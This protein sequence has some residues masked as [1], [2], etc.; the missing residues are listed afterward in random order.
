VFDIR[1]RQQRLELGGTTTVLGGNGV[2]RLLDGAE[3][4][5]L[6]S[7]MFEVQDRATI[8]DDCGGFPTVFTNTGT[9]IKSG[10]TGL[11]TFEIAFHNSGT[12]EVQSGTLS[13]TGGFVQTAGSLTLTGGNVIVRDVLDIV[14]GTLAG[15]GAISGN[16]ANAGTVS[17]GTASAPTGILTVNGS[18]GQT[19]TGV[20]DIEIGGRV[21][22]SEY[23]RLAV[24]G[25][26]SLGGT[27]NVNT[28][29]GFVPQPS[30]SFDVLTFGS[31]SGDF[32]TKNVPAITVV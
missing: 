4:R 10:G 25:L 1:L 9:F 12:L 24:G 18:Y 19:S 31:R 30:D 32:A 26:A 13:F 15:A 14:A 23:D 28:I 3:I 17:P 6:A 20:L 22:G 11:S 27:L 8:L 7:G 5:N 21:A 29:S 2:W 16:V